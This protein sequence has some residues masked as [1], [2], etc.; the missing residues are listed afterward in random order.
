MTFR[1]INYT[2]MTSSSRTKKWI[3]TLLFF[4]ASMKSVQSYFFFHTKYTSTNKHDNASDLIESRHQYDPYEKDA[5]NPLYRPEF[6]YIPSSSPSNN[7][8][9]MTFTEP[10]RTPTLTYSFVPSR[11]PSIN[12]QPSKTPT[13]SITKNMPT[14]YPTVSNESSEL[15][16]NNSCQ[17]NNGLYGLTSSSITSTLLEVTTVS[18]NYQIIYSTKPEYMDPF[19]TKNE[20]NIMLEEALGNNLLKELWNKECGDDTSLIPSPTNSNSGNVTLDSSIR[21]I[22]KMEKYDSMDNNSFIDVVGYSNK[23]PDQIDDTIQCP[24]DQITLLRDDD[25]CTHIQGRLSLYTINVSDSVISNIISSTQS[26]IQT[27]MESPNNPLFIH[28]SILSITYMDPNIKY[29]SKATYSKSS[30]KMNQLNLVYI[31]TPV[32]ATTLGLLILL[33]YK[34]NKQNPLEQYRIKA[35]N[36]LED[37]V[38]Y[39]K[40][41]MS[42]IYGLNRSLQDIN[43]DFD[44]D[45]TMNTSLADDS[46]VYFPDESNIS[47]SESF[48]DHIDLL[49]DI[50][51]QG[52]ETSYRTGSITSPTTVSGIQ[53]GSEQK[54]PQFEQLFLP[55][56]H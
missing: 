47:S 32:F 11:S 33:R 48:Q 28:P 13:Q 25:K 37:E 38:P 3:L 34:R 16:G 52:I 22:R 17:L 42:P 43:Q 53:I 30:S 49:D 54:D 15:T 31:L 21:R 19:I 10:S 29:F 18:F 39:T 8:T 26:R 35:P 4:T 23:P 50:S 7:P 41:D 24:Y 2:N 27:I 55:H 5:N 1:L 14:S 6:T 40:Y 9:Y 45:T 44:N 51:F 12:L 36:I 46:T 20:L 56:H